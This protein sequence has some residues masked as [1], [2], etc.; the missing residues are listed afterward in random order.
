MPAGAVQVLLE[1][2]GR[3]KQR[4]GLPADA[5]VISCY[6]AGRDGFWLHRFLGPQGVENH[7]VDSASIEVN[8]RYRRAKTER[9]DVHKL[10][11][12]LLRHVA[13]EPKVWSVVRVPSEVDEDRRQLHRELL[14]AKRDRTRVIN[15][16]QGLLAGVGRRMALAGEVEAQLEQGPSVGWRAAAC[17]LAGAAAGVL[18]DP[19][20]HDAGGRT[21][22]GTP[23]SCGASRGPGPP[24]GHP[25]RD[26]DQ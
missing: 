2:I 26:W 19:T 1:E 15:R 12:M 20:D 23:H 18:P 16:M 5:P 13:G 3:A 7:V 21:A 22:G 17:G 25:A 10:L 14:T 9:L 24:V 11:T 4:F 6:E 8:R